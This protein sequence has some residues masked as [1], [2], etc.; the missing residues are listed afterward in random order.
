V[1]GAQRQLVAVYADE[2]C[3]GNGRD[4]DNPGGAAGVVELLNRGG[5]VVRRDFWISEAATTNNRMALHSVI[6]AFSCL[7]AK[8]N[9]F[10]VLFTSDSQYLILGMTDWVHGWAA[11]GWRRKSGPIENLDLWHEAIRTVDGHRVEWRWVRGHDG[12]PQNAYADHLATGAAASLSNSNG[13]VES[14]FE[15][16]VDSEIRGKRIRVPPDPFPDHASFRPS[17]S[18]PAPPAALSL[19]APHT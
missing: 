11:R 8:D 19:R 5:Q 12:H 10:D 17:R 4:G 6:A 14:R 18:L 3:I 16:W 15:S 13:L 9:R 1:T 2:S 7:G